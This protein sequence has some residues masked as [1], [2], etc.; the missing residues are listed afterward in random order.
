MA[1]G[2]PTRWPSAPSISPYPA[3]TGARNDRI[4]CPAKPANKPAASSVEKRRPP[5]HVAGMIPDTPYRASVTGCRG[6]NE[7]GNSKPSVRSNPLRTSR[8]NNFWYAAPSAPRRAGGVRDRAMQKRGA[9]MVESVSRGDIRMHPRQAVFGQGQ[10]AQSWKSYPQR[11]NRRTDVV[12][13]TRQRQL[14]RARAASRSVGGLGHIRS[15]LSI[16]CGPRDCWQRRSPLSAA[17]RSAAFHEWSCR[18]RLPIRWSA[19]HQRHRGGR[20]C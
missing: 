7:S 4:E 14:G 9:T 18:S 12:H 1:I 16:S 3:V 15:N 20:A 5:T 2:Q 8:P 13:E 11:V 10:I 17:S 19:H 6:G